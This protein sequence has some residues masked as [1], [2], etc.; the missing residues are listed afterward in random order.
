Q[1]ALARVTPPGARAP[2]LSGGPRAGAGLPSEESATLRPSWAA[3]LAPLPASLAPCWLHFSLARV[4]AHTAPAPELSSG[5]PMTAVLPSEDSATPEPKCAAPLSPLPVSFA[6]CWLQVE[7]VR[8]NAHA[9]PTPL[10]SPG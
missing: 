2:T 9:A 3:P 5:P 6:P 7:P 4:N 1:V 10:L 8:V